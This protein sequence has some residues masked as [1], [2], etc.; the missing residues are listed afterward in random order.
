MNAR[1]SLV[2]GLGAVAICVI[3]ALVKDPNG[4]LATAVLAREPVAYAKLAVVAVSIAAGIHAAS[5]GSAPGTTVRSSAMPGTVT[6]GLLAL[7]VVAIDLAHGVDGTCGARSGSWT[8]VDRV[9]W[10]AFS[11]ALI[12]RLWARENREGTRIATLPP[13]MLAGAAGIVVYAVVRA[14]VIDALC[15][16]R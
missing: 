5:R 16:L 13:A 8:F 4:P 14:Y 7:G 3:G 6:L 11:L 15:S 1:W 9:A 12:R 10:L 2:C